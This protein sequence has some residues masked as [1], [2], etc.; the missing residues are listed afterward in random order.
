MQSPII[1]QTRFADLQRQRPDLTVSQ[2]IN[3]NNYTLEEIQSGKV[4]LKA[5]PVIPEKADAVVVGAGMA[6]LIFAIHLKKIKPDA[7]IVVLERSAQPTYKIGESTLSTFSR[8]CQSHIMSSQYMLRLFN[9]K[10]GLDFVYLDENS[11]KKHYQDIGGLDYSFQLERKVSE[12]LFTLKAQ[13]MGVK[14]IQYTLGSSISSPTPDA[15]ARSSH[16]APLQMQQGPPITRSASISLAPTHRAFSVDVERIKTLGKKRSNLFL[17]MFGGKNKSPSRH[18]TPRAPVIQAKIVA[19]ASGLTQ[20]IAKQ[21]VKTE[22]FPGMD[23]DAYWAYF[24]EDMV[25]M[26]KSIS[27]YEYPGS[28][29]LC[30]KGWLELV[31]SSRHLGKISPRQPHGF[32]HLPP[33]QRLT[34]VS[35]KR[36]VPCMD[37]LSAMFGCTHERIVS[38]GFTLR[39]ESVATLP[40]FPHISP[41]ASENEKRFWGIVHKKYYGPIFG[42]F[43]ARKSIS[44]RQTAVAGPGWFAMGNASGF[45]SPLFSPGIN[46][47]ALPQAFLA[48]N[49]AKRHLRPGEEV[50]D[51][52]QHRMNDVQIPGLRMNYQKYFAESEIHWSL[53][54]TSPVFQEFAPEILP[55]IEGLP[56][57]PISDETM[58]QVTL[59]CE[60]YR[61]MAVDLYSAHTKYSLYMRFYGDDLKPA[62]ARLVDTPNYMRMKREEEE[63]VT[64]DSAVMMEKRE[65]PQLQVAEVQAAA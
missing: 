61:Q 40:S 22:K 63:R 57:D 21:L 51:E 18:P 43:F 10:E 30:M 34:Q 14:T 53:G 39:S 11:D 2:I 23:F 56:N 41:K 64:P 28:I 47:I 29:H 3:S 16:D 6:G 65:L 45:T 17:R 27:N 24:K 4:D 42:T 48:G 8:F 12:L 20:T 33:R 46:C 35:T 15:A 52:Y 25:N 49:L 9:I 44:Y 58:A 7:V 50:W 5:D 1:P 26:E 55:L 19:D 59:I 13:R 62:L 32:D 31:D 60:K 37:T 54:S 38:I 36:L